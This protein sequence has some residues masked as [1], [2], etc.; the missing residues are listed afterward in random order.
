MLQGDACVIA[1]PRVWE[2]TCLSML[3]NAWQVPCS[4]LL[5]MISLLL[6]SVVVLV[7][8]FPCPA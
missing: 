4:P 2:V 3:V 1:V 5:M 6:A 7:G 8:S